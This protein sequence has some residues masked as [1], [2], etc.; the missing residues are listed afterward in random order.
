M[1]G[2]KLVNFTAILILVSFVLTGMVFADDFTAFSG[3]INADKINLRADATIG[4]PVICSLAKGQLVD[5]VGQAYDWYKIRL[6]KEAASYVNKNLVECINSETSDTQPVTTKCLNA[7]V[8]KD[9]INVR[10]GPSES[11][12]ILGKADKLTVLNILGQEGDWY[13]IQPIYQSY[14]WVNKKFVNKELILPKKIENTS[15]PIKEIQ[16]PQPLVLEGTISPYGVVL[17][18]KATHKL[19]T[20]ENKVYLLKGDRKGLDSLNYK[21]VKVSGKLITPA[22]NKYPI[23]EINIIEALN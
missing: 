23:L 10:L 4:S 14:G 9:R 1:R 17:W 18:R 19:I 21:K 6:P 5:V 20:A 11:T 2:F 22:E 3:Q 13:K 8:I 12:W 15:Q 7:K 16:P